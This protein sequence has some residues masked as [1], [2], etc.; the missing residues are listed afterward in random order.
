MPVYGTLSPKSRSMYGANIFSRGLDFL[1]RNTGRLLR[2]GVSVLPRLIDTLV[3]R[4]V[5]SGHINPSHGRI[6][7]RLREHSRMVPSLNPLISRLEERLNLGVQRPLDR[8]DATLD[9]IAERGLEAIERNVSRLA[10]EVRAQVEPQEG[11]RLIKKKGKSSKKTKAKVTKAKP[12]K[13]KKKVK[14][15]DDMESSEYR[16]MIRSLIK[17]TKGGSIDVH[18][19]N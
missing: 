14:V 6:Y 9:N 1:R 5:Q 17:T 11:G 4:G 15:P 10:P 12:S 13:T 19:L 2:T 7:Q 16:S 18:T 3:N 8:T